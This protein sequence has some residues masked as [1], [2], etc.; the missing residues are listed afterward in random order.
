MYACLGYAAH[1]L[2][3]TSYPSDTQQVIQHWAS[4]QCL[5]AN[6]PD[7]VHTSTSS[8]LLS[9]R[10]I[11]SLAPPS[12]TPQEAAHQLRI[13]AAASQSRKACQNFL[14]LRV[15]CHQLLL[16]LRLLLCLQP[17]AWLLVVNFWISRDQLCPARH[18]LAGGWAWGLAPAPAHTT[19]A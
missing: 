7:Q 2:K 13:L 6:L 12:T 19:A 3:C 18:A 15:P 5:I 4:T 9:T 17:V 14:L 1:E 10:H 11:S 8:W 16:C